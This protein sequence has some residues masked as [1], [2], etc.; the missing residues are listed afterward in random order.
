MKFKCSHITNIS[1]HHFRLSNALNNQ[2]FE[3][4]LKKAGL[5]VGP[6]S[7]GVLPTRRLRQSDQADQADDGEGEACKGIVNDWRSFNTS[8][9]KGVPGVGGELD[10]TETNNTIGTL[11]KLNNK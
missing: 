5:D 6:G 3:N 1:S 4:A 7:D 9:D 11:D 8:A 10:E 2:G